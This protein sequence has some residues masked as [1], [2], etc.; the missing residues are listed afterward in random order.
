ML[1]RSISLD[2]V[3][4]NSILVATD[5]T[6]ASDR[7]LQ[8]GIAIARHYRSKLYVAYVVSSV[9]FTI[10]G[11]DAIQIAAEATERDLDNHLNQL[12]RSG[13]LH[14]VE[15]CPVVLQGNIDEAIE[16][17]ASNHHVDL[18]VTGTHGRQ[19]A[20]RLLFGSFAEMISQSCSCPVLTVGP[21]SSAPW[22]DEPAVSEGPLLFATAFDNASAKAIPYAISMANDFERQ[23]YVL[24][25]MPPH[26]SFALSRN[27]EAHQQK[28]AAAL[29]HLKCLTHPGTALRHAAK[30]L[31]E[32]CDPADGIIRTASR[33]H[34]AAIIMGAQHD[35]FCQLTAR[36]PWHISQQVNR[37]AQCPVLTVRD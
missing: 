1:E 36:F 18:V 7:A 21:H 15:V 13:T 24:H 28:E 29:A 37:E 26:Q 6:R 2:R 22:L 23:L 33:I 31:V 17:F 35:A 25:V 3:S 27:R 5:F 16:S 14:G 12:R 30:A 4:L 19:G 9:A 11:P 20:E 32:F 34:A 10:A 8:H